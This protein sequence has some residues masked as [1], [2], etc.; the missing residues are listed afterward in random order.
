MYVYVCM[1]KYGLLNS[2][3]DFSIVWLANPAL[4][5]RA[6]ERQCEAALTHTPS[7]INRNKF[8][9]NARQSLHISKDPS[10]GDAAKG[11]RSS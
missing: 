9:A 10:G 5:A 4:L 2:R 8:N 1:H 7:Q 3:L 6:G 11:Q